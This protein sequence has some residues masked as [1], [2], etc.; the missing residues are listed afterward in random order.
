MASTLY[1]GSGSPYGWKVWL[2]LEHKKLPYELRVMSF[3]AGETRTPEFRAISPRG[4]IPALVLEDGT[5]ILESSAIVEYLEEAHPTPSILPGD[6]KNRAR[7]R[8]FASESDDYLAK[9]INKMVELVLFK[10]PADRNAEHIAEATKNLLP[11]LDY[12]AEQTK[13]GQWLAGSE[14]TLADYAVYP[15][16]GFLRRLRDRAPEHA[17]AIPPAL[18]AW[19]QRVEALPYFARTLPPHWKPAPT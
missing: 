18:E 5:A 8:R 19:M 4:K 13:S 12:W 2:V 1:Y 15:Q 11:E 16:L 3:Q 7:A 9:A 14:V 10:S 17:V 6:A